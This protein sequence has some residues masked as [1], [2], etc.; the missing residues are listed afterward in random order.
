MQ[1]NG[2]F[3]GGRGPDGAGAEER[4]DKI[5]SFEPGYRGRLPSRLFRFFKQ[6]AQTSRTGPPSQTS[7]KP[8]P[9]PPHSTW[10]AQMPRTGPQPRIT[11]NRVE[12]PWIS[13]ITLKQLERHP[14][15][16]LDALDSAHPR[17][18]LNRLTR[19]KYSIC[20]SIMMI[21]HFHRHQSA[22]SITPSN[23]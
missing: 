11:P 7:S 15:L 16:S 2:T 17:P 21:V 5:H 23:M 14:F 20:P 8:P 19:F 22:S 1:Q 9:K 10:G 4:M 12:S 18:I 13:Q 3:E 6:R